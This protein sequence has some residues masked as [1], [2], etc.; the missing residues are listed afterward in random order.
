[1]TAKEHA[2]QTSN[3]VDSTKPHSSTES[4]SSNGFPAP[5]HC[6]LERADLCEHKQKLKAEHEKTVN[7]VFL[8][9]RTFHELTLEIYRKCNVRSSM[10]TQGQ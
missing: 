4:F 6:D 1:M 8:S 3:K 2:H 10:S 7:Y 9:S 5:T